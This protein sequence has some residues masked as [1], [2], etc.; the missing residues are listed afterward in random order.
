[1]K[2]TLRRGNVTEALTK[3]ANNAEV[4]PDGAERIFLGLFAY[5][6]ELGENGNEYLFAAL[7]EAANGTRRR[8]VNHL[9]SGWSRFVRFWPEDPFTNARLNR[10][11]SYSVEQMASGYFI[12]NALERVV[13]D[14]VKRN[15]WAWFPRDGKEMFRTGEARLQNQANA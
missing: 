15:L 10:W 12:F 9:C 13:G 14:A 3:L 8:A 4:V 11:Y 2:S 6:D 1:M 5:E 7:Q